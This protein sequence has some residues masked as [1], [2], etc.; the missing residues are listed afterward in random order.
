MNNYFVQK[1][2][3]DCSRSQKTSIYL[4]GEGVTRQLLEANSNKV[5]PNVR[6]MNLSEN[7]L[8]QLDDC[9]TMFP[10]I[11]MALLSN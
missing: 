9:V 6:K 5:W 3:D 4:A 11:E 10:N 7:K 2:L 1:Y 8:E